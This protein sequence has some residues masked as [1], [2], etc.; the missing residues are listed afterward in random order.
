M[1]IGPT[2]GAVLGGI[3]NS[4]LGIGGGIW[5]NQQNVRNANTEALWNMTQAAQENEW[6]QQ[7][8]QQNRDFSLEM[9]NLNNEYNSPQEQ[10]ARLREAGLSPQLMYGQGSMGNAGS[11][12]SA[13]LSSAADIKGYTRPEAQNVLKGHDTFGNI[14]KFK[15]LQAQT[16]NVKQQERVGAQTA[17]NLATDNLQKVENLD[18]TRGTK[19]STIELAKNNQEIAAELAAQGA[20]K[21]RTERLTATAKVAKARN[22]ARISYQKV[23]NESIE[24]QIQAAKLLYHEYVGRHAEDDINV[25]DNIFIRQI[26]AG[27]FSD[28]VLQGIMSPENYAI[29]KRYIKK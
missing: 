14:Y 10:M 27:G 9:W 7:I 18:I 1:P 8:W 5:Q 13:N 16:D 23:K 11:P 2:G 19:D 22:E 21:T 28:K 26:S 25:Q 17:L 6:N 20:I 3:A 15:N 29:Y 4:I 24:V 12:P